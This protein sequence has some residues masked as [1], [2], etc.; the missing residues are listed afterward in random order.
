M[1]DSVN[2]A[3]FVLQ[4]PLRVRWSEIDIQGIVFN[5]HYLNYFDVAIAE[6]WRASKFQYPI[7]FVDVYQADFFVVRAVVEYHGS[8][9]YD[10]LIDVCA[11]AAKFGR[12]SLKF[13]MAVFRGEELLVTGELTYVCANPSTRKS[14]FIPQPMRDLLNGFETKP[15][16]Q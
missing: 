2:K 8:A 3:D 16:E 15:I 4:H 11:R 9:R 13:E 7:G 5:G 10:E 14:Q 1:T 12:S 6:Y